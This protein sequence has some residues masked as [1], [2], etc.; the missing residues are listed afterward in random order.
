MLRSSFSNVLLQLNS[1]Y[2]VYLFP[3]ILFSKLFDARQMLPA[4]FGS[5][6]E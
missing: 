3:V 2:P 6:I 4:E 1:S 5:I